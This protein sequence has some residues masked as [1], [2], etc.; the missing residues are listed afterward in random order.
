MSARARVL[1]AR[2]LTVGSGVVVLASLL[3]TP[4]QA[5][6]ATSTATK[7]RTVTGTSVG[8]PFGPVQVSVRVVA[9]KVTKVTPIAYPRSDPRSA[10]INAYAIPVLQKQALAAQSARLAGV[11]GA[12]YS[13][14]AFAQSL[15]SALTKAGL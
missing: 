4:A 7:A 9:G 14:N 15:Q 6:E 3:T 13:S 8:T 11:S 1:A 5:A 10:Q 12:S 2:S